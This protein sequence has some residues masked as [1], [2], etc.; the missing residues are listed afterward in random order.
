MQHLFWRADK[1]REEYDEN[2]LADNIAARMT[3]NKE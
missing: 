1:L 2:K 3:A